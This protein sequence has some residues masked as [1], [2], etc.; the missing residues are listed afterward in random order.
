MLYRPGDGTPVVVIQSDLI[1]GMATQVVIPLI[2]QRRVASTI[3][4]LNPVIQVDGAPHVLMPQLMASLP[5]TALRQPVGDI[6]EHRDTITRAI[7]TLL[8]GV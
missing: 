4:R 2:P 7:D 6:A 8:S 1:L 5:T 3:A